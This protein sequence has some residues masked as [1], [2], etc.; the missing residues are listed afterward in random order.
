[1]YLYEYMQLCGCW[2]TLDKV[3][4]ECMQSFQEIPPLYELMKRAWI[5]ENGKCTLD[6]NGDRKR[7]GSQKSHALILLRAHVGYNG[8]RR[9]E[10]Q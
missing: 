7:P 1:M 2:V 3:W 8:D 5:A 4:N 6:W 9:A 10:H